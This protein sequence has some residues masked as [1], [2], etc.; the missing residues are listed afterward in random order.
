MLN[1]VN[2]IHFYYYSS[3]S[4]YLLEERKFGKTSRAIEAD[5]RQTYSLLN[6]ERDE[7]KE[8]Y[9][10][11][12]DS[13]L[14]MLREIVKEKTNNVNSYAIHRP[15][16]LSGYVGGIY[17]ATKDTKIF[18]KTSIMGAVTNLLLTFVLVW[19]GGVMGAAIASPVSYG[20]IWYL[21]IKGINKYMNMNINLFKDVFG[22]IILLIQTVLLFIFPDNILFFILQLLAIVILLLLNKELLSIVII[23]ITN[24]FIKR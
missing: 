7:K 11:T 5:V 17:A 23:K 3:Y 14:Y 10:T 9:L 1:F 13:T 20:L 21:R 6:A 8:Y 19:K 24:K 2:R 22:Y 16:A 12:W 18:A 15:G 4:N